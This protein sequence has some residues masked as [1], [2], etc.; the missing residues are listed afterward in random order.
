MKQIKSINYN[1]YCPDGNK[2]IELLTVTDPI[3]F[4][5]LVVDKSIPKSAYLAFANSIIN[6]AKEKKIHTDQMLVSM[7]M[8]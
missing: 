3:K 6:L 7:N 4:N 2:K 1:F 8:N 5:V